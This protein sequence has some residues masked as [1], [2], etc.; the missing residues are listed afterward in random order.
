MIIQSA[1][2]YLNGQVLVIDKPK[3]W[4]SFQVVKKIRFLIKKIQLKKNKSWT[5]W[6]FRSFSN[7]GFN[8]MYRKTNQKNKSYSK[9][10]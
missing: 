8:I 5:C 9:S 3:G 4:T 2:A 6:H 7:R 10:K 1:E